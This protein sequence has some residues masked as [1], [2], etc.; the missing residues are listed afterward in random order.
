MPKGDPP[1]QTKFEIVAIRFG[2]R[3]EQ[4]AS[5]RPLFER[6]QGQRRSARGFEVI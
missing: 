6:I 3:C 2:S 5:R 4:L 1:F